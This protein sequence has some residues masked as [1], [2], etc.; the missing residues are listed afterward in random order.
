MRKTIA[1][2]LVF[3]MALGLCSCKSSY[4][5]KIGDVE[6]A[7]EDTCGAKDAD[8]DQYDR[9]VDNIFSV[10]NEAEYFKDG[11]YTKVSSSDYTFFPFHA[12]IDVSDVK[13]VFKYLKADPDS[14]ESGSVAQMEVLVI[15]FSK[16]AYAQNYFDLILN[17]RK[18]TYEN[19]EDLGEGIKNEFV[20]KKEYFAFASESEFMSYN[21]YASIDGSTVF[22]AFVQGPN[23][24]SLKAEYYDFMNKM[25]CSI[26]SM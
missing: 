3:I 14:E 8:D 5:A 9:M 16:S 17:S 26:I 4:S 10:A 6:D 25:E 24:D 2:G 18:K 12:T 15:Q 19:N 22:Y 7:L 21:V 23:A 13:S 11:V 20:E 1:L